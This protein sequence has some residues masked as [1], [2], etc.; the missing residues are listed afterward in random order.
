MS[1]V[2]LRKSLKVP[3]IIRKWVM[4]SWKLSQFLAFLFVVF[5]LNWNI[6][7]LN[8]TWN[9]I[10]KLSLF[11]FK[12]KISEKKTFS[13]VIS[14]HLALNFYKH[15]SLLLFFYYRKIFIFSSHENCSRLPE[16]NVFLLRFQ[17]STEK[18]EW[19]NLSNVNS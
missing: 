13:V 12:K 8:E 14:Q 11:C 4:E 16:E 5:I 17:H 6:K 7:L 18:G 10:F 1:L 15:V 9:S 3:R 2:A 19:K